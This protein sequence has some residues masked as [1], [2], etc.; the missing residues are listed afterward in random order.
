MLE[1]GCQAWTDTPT[2]CFHA[3]HMWTHQKMVG[4]WWWQLL[5]DNQKITLF[6]LFFCGNYH[7]KYVVLTR[8]GGGVNWVLKK[9]ANHAIVNIL[10]TPCIWS[11]QEDRNGTKAG[12]QWWPINNHSPKVSHPASLPDKATMNTTTTHPLP[13]SLCQMSPNRLVFVV[14]LFHNT[15]NVPPGCVFSVSDL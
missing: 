5:C 12:K 4:W 9:F 13:P 14:R 11:N 8:K 3:W 1:K 6:G 7:S 2:W 10:D 15:E